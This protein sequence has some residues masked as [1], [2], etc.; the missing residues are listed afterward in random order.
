LAAADHF[1][2]FKEMPA[3]GERKGKKK[4]ERKFR[5]EGFRVS[6]LERG[7]EGE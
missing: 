7:I 5:N 2:E 3:G 4:N 6:Y 1:S